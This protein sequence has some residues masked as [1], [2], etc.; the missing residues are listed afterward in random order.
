ML[1]KMEKSEKSRIIPELTGG[2]ISV[3][4]VKIQSYQCIDFCQVIV[5]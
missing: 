5:F 4:E 1:G 2:A 3:S